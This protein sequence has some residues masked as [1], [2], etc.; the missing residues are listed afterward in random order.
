VCVTVDLVWFLHVSFPAFAFAALYYFLQ[1][2][3]SLHAAFTWYYALCETKT[4]F[5]IQGA[6]QFAE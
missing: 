1:Q 3:S 6:L 2:D 4:C 5:H